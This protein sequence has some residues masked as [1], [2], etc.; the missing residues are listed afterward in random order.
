MS[1]SV[2]ECQSVCE[3]VRECESVKSGFCPFRLL[4]ALGLDLGRFCAKRLFCLNL[5]DSRFRVSLEWCDPHPQRA[6]GMSQTDAAQALGRATF[7]AMEESEAS[8]EK[9]KDECERHAK[10]RERVRECM[11]I[12][13]WWKGLQGRAERSCQIHQ[14]PVQEQ[15]NLGHDGGE[16]EVSQRTETGSQVRN[17]L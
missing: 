3:S 5:R 7:E 14:E 12:G 9:G 1:E 2:R 11:G 13:F 6:T 17:K 16:T 4:V 15:R 8:L 10:T